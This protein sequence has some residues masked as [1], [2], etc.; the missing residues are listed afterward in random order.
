MFKLRAVLFDLGNTLIERKPRV[1]EDS[2][3]EIAAALGQPAPARAQLTGLRRQL[4]AIESE[5]WSRYG[6]LAS[7]LGTLADEFAFL[8]KPFYPAVLQRFGLEHPRP[9]LLHRLAARQL[10]PDTFQLLPGAVST[11]AW[12][13][14]RGLRLACVS[15]SSFSAEAQLRHFDLES[16]FDV[17]TLSHQV[18]YGKP[19]RKIHLRTLGKLGVQG[20][21]AA[22][23][24]DRLEFVLPV[25]DLY[26]RAILLDR[27]GSHPEA[28]VPRIQGLAELLP[29]LDREQ[30]AMRDTRPVWVRWFA[31]PMPVSQFR[32]PLPRAEAANAGRR[33]KT[34][35]T[36]VVLG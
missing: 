15:N 9:E 17:L 13:K 32:T 35:L 34:T 2:L 20:Q 24:D 14:A 22:Y 18:G 30:A 33:L 5:T 23:L 12:L 36:R 16:Y 29:L 1:D 27:D 31:N 25:E 19:G 7:T 6:D 8:L 28:Q 21:S 11:L 10:G 26:W 4:R 3:R